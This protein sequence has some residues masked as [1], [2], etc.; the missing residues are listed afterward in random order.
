M[1]R[2]KYLET[3]ELIEGLLYIPQNLYFL[4]ELYN[5]IEGHLGN[6][7]HCYYISSDY[8]KKKYFC[9]LYKSKRRQPFPI[10]DLY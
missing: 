6:Y 2:V 3:R 4:Q 8:N 9:Q 1:S 5:L 10:F 7:Y